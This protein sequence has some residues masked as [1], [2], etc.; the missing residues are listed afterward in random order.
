[1]DGGR[2]VQS[3]NFRSVFLLSWTLGTGFGFHRLTGRCRSCRTQVTRVHNTGLREH[4]K[5]IRIKPSVMAAKPSQVLHMG[6][7]QGQAQGPWGESAFPTWPCL[8]SVGWTILTPWAKFVLSRALL[9]M[10]LVWLPQPLRDITME[11]MHE[12]R[13]TPLKYPRHLPRSVQ[14]GLQVSLLHKVHLHADNKLS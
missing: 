7:R 3:G 14:A 6:K 5:Y 13:A 4:F 9:T 1:M 10:Q 12:P 11:C 8:H 2:A